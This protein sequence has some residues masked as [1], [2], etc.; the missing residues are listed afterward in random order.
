M[1]SCHGLMVLFTIFY[2]FKHWSVI[3]IARIIAL[4]TLLMCLLL[5]MWCL[6]ESLRDREEDGWGEVD[7]CIW[8]GPTTSNKWN[9]QQTSRQVLIQHTY[10]YLVHSTGKALLQLLVQL[11]L[12]CGCCCCCCSVVDCRVRHS[13]IVRRTVCI[14]SVREWEV[15]QFQ[16]IIILA[17]NFRTADPLF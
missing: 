13:Y 11:W 16:L 4:I 15:V 17:V 8:P 10:S 9:K 14:D 2:H 5:W 12:C 7:V 6:M 1:K 3:I